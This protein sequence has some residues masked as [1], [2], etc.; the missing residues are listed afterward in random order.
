MEVMAR[1]KSK[2]SDR[3][4]ILDDLGFDRGDL[5]GGDSEASIPTSAP[6]QQSDQGGDSIRD[7]A[8]DVLLSLTDRELETLTRSLEVFARLS[9]AQMEVVGEMVMDSDIPISDSLPA[10][11]RHPARLAFCNMTNAMPRILGHT[12][13]HIGI[14]DDCVS[15]H[16]KIA[17][18]LYKALSDPD[19]FSQEDSASGFSY[20]PS[21]EMV[22]H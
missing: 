10:L 19:G 4:N 6:G 13:A 17:W 22:S 9:M 14:F 8:Q 18:D 12:G 1:G 5:S 20:T 15:D 16:G 2:K 7:R 11:A 3:I 21:E